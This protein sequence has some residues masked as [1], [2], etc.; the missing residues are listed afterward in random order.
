[1]FKAVKNFR[2][3]ILKIWTK[4]I[5]PH[6]A[7][8]SLFIQKEL[9]ERRV[10][11]VTILQVY[12]LEFKPSSIVKGKGLCKLMTESKDNEENNWKN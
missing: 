10:S 3:Y 5:V 2:P 4:V 11:W 7:V 1:M 9:G 12:D 6:L 8:R